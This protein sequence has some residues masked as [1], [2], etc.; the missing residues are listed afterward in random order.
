[1]LIEEEIFVD[2]EEDKKNICLMLTDREKEKSVIQLNI[3]MMEEKNN[4]FGISA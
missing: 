4:L 2:K 3:E 1:M